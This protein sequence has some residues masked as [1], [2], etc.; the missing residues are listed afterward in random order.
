MPLPNKP[1]RK[2]SFFSILSARSAAGDGGGPNV[3]PPQMKLEADRE[4]YRPGDP[5]TITI[6]IKNPTN[7]WSML[8]E[9]LAFEIK[10]IEKLDTQWFN[11]PKSSPDAKQRRGEIVFMD[12]STAAIVS[13]QILSSGTTKICKA[14]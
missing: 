6:E 4:V 14:E 3:K 10:G 12:C 7:S 5:I 9:K 11:T 13:N 1:S 8:I 2:F